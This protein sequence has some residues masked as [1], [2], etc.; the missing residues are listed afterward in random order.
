MAPRAS[1]W[2][3]M[4]FNGPDAQETHLDPAWMYAPMA[5]SLAT[6]P[7]FLSAL[8]SPFFRRYSEAF[9]MLLSL[10]ASARL[11]SIIPAPLLWRSSFTSLASTCTPQESVRVAW[12]Y[13]MLGN[14]DPEAQL[15][16]IEQLKA[17]LGG[18]QPCRACNAAAGSAEQWWGLHSCPPPP[19]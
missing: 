7:A 9:S 15:A 3:P 19:P 2:G 18:R 13:I 10:A 17:T 8:A 12:H 4:P 14:I 5:P 1:K 16:V 11:Q 6:L